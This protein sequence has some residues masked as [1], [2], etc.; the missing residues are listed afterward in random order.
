MWTPPPEYGLGTA[1]HKTMYLLDLA[2]GPDAQQFKVLV[3][4]G[5][6]M[7]LLPSPDCQSSACTKH[8]RLS[9]GE[10]TAQTIGIGFAWGKAQGHIWKEKVCLASSGGSE[11]LTE[12]GFLQRSSSTARERDEGASCADMGVLAVD[13]E[14]DDLASAPF[15]GIL[16]LGLRDTAV[17]ESCSFLDQLQAEGKA[18]ST[19]FALRLSNSGDSELV[20]G[21]VD[22]DSFARSRALYV[23]LSVSAGSYWQFSV[24][25]LSINGKPAQLGGLEVVVDS[26][27][28]LLAADENLKGWMKEHLTPKNCDA[29]NDLPWIGLQIS[30]EVSIPIL[31]SDYVDRENGE[32]GLALMP[33]QFS[34]VNYQRLVLGDSFMRRYT[35]IFDRA[36]RRIGFGIDAQDENKALLTQAMFP[37]A[38]TTTT[39]TTH[40][41]A[42]DLNLKYSSFSTATTTAPPTPEEERENELNSAFTGVGDLDGDFKKDLQRQQ[43]A[44]KGHAT[45]AAEDVAA[46]ISNSATPESFSSAPRTPQDATTTT[47]SEEDLAKP[48][49]LAADAADAPHNSYL[50]ALKLVQVGSSD[51]PARR[52]LAARGSLSIPLVRLAVH[53]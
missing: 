12:V 38:T 43:Q 50:D 19:N 13:Q 20:L 49:A 22:E 1:G 11:S 23:P 35:T 40:G 37:A 30:N 16:G 42:V 41:E 25:D 45:S 5:S 4:T 31:P 6:S 52:P 10:K 28:S 44:V 2:V 8:P 21:S 47:P 34:G 17:Q 18:S 46:D 48:A 32:C 26:G 53:Q 9:G 14:S 51:R 15:D 33:G 3:D 27:T 24:L 36:N 39:T 7:L 29:V